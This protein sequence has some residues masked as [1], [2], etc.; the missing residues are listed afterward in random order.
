MRHDAS[1]GNHGCFRRRGEERPMSCRL[2]REAPAA[3]ERR[4]RR[5]PG[6]AANDPLAGIACEGWLMSVRAMFEPNSPDEPYVFETGFAHDADLVGAFEAPSL[7]AGL[8]GT[9]PRGGGG[10]G[11]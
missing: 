6:P 11:P 7:S 4:L 8:A 10:W 9:G 5:G 3:G 1:H 2:R